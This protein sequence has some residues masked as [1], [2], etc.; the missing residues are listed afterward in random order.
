MNPAS[1]DFV[2]KISRTRAKAAA[3]AQRP[4][5]KNGFGIKL[6]PAPARLKCGDLLSE[7]GAQ[8]VLRTAE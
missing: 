5:G 6:F 2:G 7:M 1:F 4:S 3:L 8:N